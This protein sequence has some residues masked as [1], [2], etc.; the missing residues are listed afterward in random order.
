MSEAEMRSIIS[1]R[2]HYD[3]AQNKP[4]IPSEDIAIMKASYDGEIRYLDHHLERL[5]EFLE[6]AGRL[7]N[8]LII[9]TSD[10]GEHFGEH[11]LFVHSNSLYEELIKV[12]LIISWQEKVE[13]GLRDQLVSLVSIAPTILDAAGLRIPTDMEGNSLLSTLVGVKTEQLKTVIS[14]WSGHQAI[15][16][17]SWKGIF[18][19][20]RSEEL[21]D[22][23][24]DP[25]EKDNLAQVFPDSLSTL[26]NVLAERDLLDDIT[27]DEKIERKV[28]LPIQEQL[29][30]IG[31]VN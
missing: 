3:A 24:V 15:Y 22:L 31:Y 5:F 10:H 6:G 7:K 20:N 1:E 26:R 27:R 16:C 29:K 21:F 11:K 23:K 30:A 12:P 4:D 9:I 28:P 25:S 13:P 8:A 17:G 18:Y 19:S 14:Q 2:K